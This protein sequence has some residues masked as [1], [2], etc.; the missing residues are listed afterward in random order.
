LRRSGRRGVFRLSQFG[1]EV[2][3]FCFRH[4]FLGPRNC[5]GAEAYFDWINEEGGRKLKLVSYDD[6]CDPA[7]ARTCWGK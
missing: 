3:K 5:G 7:E 4:R 1:G 6:S 2:W